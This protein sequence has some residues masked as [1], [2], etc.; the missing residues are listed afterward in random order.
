MMTWTYGFPI[1]ISQPRSFNGRKSQ[2]YKCSLCVCLALPIE[3]FMLFQGRLSHVYKGHRCFCKFV[4]PL[5]NVNPY[6]EL[7]NVHVVGSQTKICLSLIAD[8]VLL[9]AGRSYPGMD[10]DALDQLAAEAFFDALAVQLRR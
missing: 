2:S 10:S 8:N 7:R 4:S 6:T 5:S 9:L 3:L 1:L